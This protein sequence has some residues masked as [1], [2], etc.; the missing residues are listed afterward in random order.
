MCHPLQPQTCPVRSPQVPLCFR[1][2]HQAPQSV[3]FAALT[4]HRPCSTAPTCAC[5]SVWHRRLCTSALRCERAQGNLWLL[6]PWWFLHLS[7]VPEQAPATRGYRLGLLI[8]ELRGCRHAARESHQLGSHP[9]R[10][11]P[12]P[13]APISAEA[14]HAAASPFPRAAPHT[15]PPLQP[16]PSRTGRGAPARDQRSAVT[17]A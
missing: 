2:G 3:H 11:P 9:S 12:L 14:A 6:A 17:G 1:Q 10:L 13:L 7:A 15:A 4:P 8:Q 5:S 16:P